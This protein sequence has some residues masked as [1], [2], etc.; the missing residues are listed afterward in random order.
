MAEILFKNINKIY[1]NNVQAVYDFN[2]NVNDKEFVVFVGPSGCGKSTTLRMVAGLEEITSGELFVNGRLMNNIVPKDRDVAMV[3][4]N[5]ALY[6]N[7]TVRKNIGFSLTHRKV[8][9][10][11]FEPDSSKVKMLISENKKIIRK[12]KRIDL[13]NKKPNK[14]E[15]L[16]KNRNNLFSKL[17]ENDEKIK[18]LRIQRFGI[19]ETRIKKCYDAI[20]RNK[21]SIIKMERNIERLK[22]EEKKSVLKDGI[23]QKNKQNK[24][25]EED[26]VFLK[27]NKVS[28]S[29]PRKLKNFEIEIEVNKA[30]E[31][32]G[33]IPYL[34][35]KPGALSGGQRQRVALGRAIV[36]HPKIFLMDEPLSNLDAKLR[37]QMR[38]EITKIHNNVGATTIYV[39]HDQTEAMTMASKIVIMKNGYIQQIGTPNEVYNNPSN[40]FVG[41]FIGNPAM[42]FIEVYYSNGILTTK[43]KTNFAIKVKNE[44]KKSLSQY[45]GKKLLLGVRPENVYLKG[46]KN[47]DKPSTSFTSTVIYDELLGHDY[48]LYCKLGGN[49]LVMKT[50]FKNKLKFG[51]EV[52]ICFDLNKMYYFDIKTENRIR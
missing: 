21:N 31:I 40:K 4:Q 26:I 51:T 19:D 23:E 52:D 32:L 14:N 27:N 29:K 44:D 25:L 49:T 2:L 50:A 1:S 17:V 5:Y 35:R 6:P 30:A 22:N 47:N 34:E 3:F 36:R 48:M 37:V 12:L 33:L 8:D 18:N 11:I 43:G 42:N 7:M 28:L 9:M 13:K 16:S 15:D 24:A 38:N 41:G 10:P 20:E 39:T 46:D 45:E